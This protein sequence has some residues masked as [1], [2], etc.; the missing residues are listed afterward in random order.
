MELDFRGHPIWLRF[1][2]TTSPIYFVWIYVYSTYSNEFML[3]CSTS[4]ICC[5]LALLKL[6]TM[7]DM[8]DLISELIDFIRADKDVDTLPHASTREETLERFF[9]DKMVL[10]Q[11][12]S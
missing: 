4:Y 9:Q 6:I 3:V 10:F 5:A 7:E 11:Q 12:I 8:F 2:Q 1:W